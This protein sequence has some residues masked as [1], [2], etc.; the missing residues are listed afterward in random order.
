MKNLLYKELKLSLHPICYIFP[1]LF[2]FMIIIPNYPAYVS[3]IY[4]LVTYPIL[5]LGANKGETTNDLFYSCNLPIRKKDVVKARL[6]SVGF[7]QLLGFISIAIFMPLGNLI[8]IE[9]ESA[10]SEGVAYI[11]LGKESFIALLG[12]VLIGYSIH[13]LI[14]FPWFYKTGKSIIGPTLVSVLVFCLYCGVVITGIPLAVVPLQKLLNVYEG[15]TVGLLIQFGILLLGV[16][17]YSLSRIF[18]YKVSSKRLEN[19]DL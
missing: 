1:L 12:L 15:G 3:C 10:S 16:I 6:L 2:G 17:I 8:N 11:G 13:D 4:T 14:F 18:I 19:L 5:F 9:I 7:L